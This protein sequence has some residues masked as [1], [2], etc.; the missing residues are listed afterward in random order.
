MAAAL[1]CAARR[2]CNHALQRPQAYFTTAAEAA[3]KEGRR[4]LL[5]RISHGASSLRRFSLSESTTLLLNSNNTKPTEG[6]GKQIE[7]KKH[8]LLGL[9]GKMEAESSM[10]AE[11]KELQQVLLI[12]N[13]RFLVQ[14]YKG[15]VVT[16]IGTMIAGLATA[17]VGAKVFMPRRKD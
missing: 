11:H 4:R 16:G 12:N 7:S 15:A 6:L 2:I 14:V 5:P 13:N 3:V 17:I 9:L 1:R 8:E 10:G